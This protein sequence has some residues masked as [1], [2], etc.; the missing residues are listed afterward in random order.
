LRFPPIVNQTMNTASSSATSTSRKN[1][2]IAK[3]PKLVWAAVVAVCAACSTLPPPVSRP[4]PPSTGPLTPEPASAGFRPAA[5]EAIPGWAEDTLADVWP[6][7]SAGC[8]ALVAQPATATIWAEPC[9]TATTI[10][11]RDAAAVRALFERHF[12]AYQALAPDGKE[13]GLVTGYYEPLLNGSRV[14]SER[15]RYPLYATPDDLLTIDLA[16][17]YPELKDKRLR[18]RVDGNRVVPY[19]PR[20][21]IESGRAPLVGKELVFVDDPVEAFFLHIQGSGRVRLAE[22]GVMRVGYADQ[23][24][25]PF[26]SIAR[27]LIDRGELTPDK[28]SM[29]AI[30]RWAQ[31]HPEALPALLDENPS[32]VFFRE[33]TPDPGAAIDG[34]IGTLGVPLAAG[35]SIAVDARSIPLGAPVFLATT[36]PLSTRPLNRLVLAQ[37]TGGAIRG[38]LRVDFFWGFG[39]DAAREAGRM[40]QETRLWLLWPKSAPPPR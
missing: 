35:R 34:P 27:V 12:T 24:G 39:E 22:G 15:N 5:F 13:T 33:V 40:K 25:Q 19:W 2:T 9:A 30:K 38:P 14:R 8:A 3:L 6:A 4:T 32:Y 20:A 18:G 7:F 11:P 36:W 23:N 37:D 16:E 28:A 31:Q 21:D 10:D 17:L 29:Q 1:Q 26:R